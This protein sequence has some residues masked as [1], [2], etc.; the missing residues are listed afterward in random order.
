MARTMSDLQAMDEIADWLEVN[1]PTLTGDLPNW[2]WD[3][4]SL[5]DDLIDMSGRNG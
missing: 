1:D 2:V 3:L 4:V 5:V